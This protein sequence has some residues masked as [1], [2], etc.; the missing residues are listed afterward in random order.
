MTK[1]PVKDIAVGSFFAWSGH[2]WQR[3]E[4]TDPITLTNAWVKD[5]LAAG[6]PLAEIQDIV[7]L[8]VWT[9]VFPATS[10][11]IWSAAACWYFLPNTEVVP[12]NLSTALNRIEP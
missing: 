3:I 6:T 12:C 2:K 9:R 4:H 11:C 5:T 10:D 7:K 8:Y 1:V